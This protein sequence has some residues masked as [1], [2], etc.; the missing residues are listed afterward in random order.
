MRASNCNRFWIGVD[1]A[2]ESLEAA[3]VDEEDSRRDW[4]TLAVHS[5][6]HLAASMRHFKSWLEAHGPCAGIV[7]ESTGACTAR[8]VDALGRLEL[9]TPAVINPARSCAFAKSLGLRDKSDRID[10]AM[11]AICGAAHR[12]AA[13]ASLPPT[14]RRL[15]ALDRLGEDLLGQRVQID[16]RLGEALDPLVAKIVRAARRHPRH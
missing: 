9:A 4:R 14:R 7:I 8:F 5:F 16:N 1:L 11:L 6:D 10:A 15:R 2:K 12:P 3:A 13:S